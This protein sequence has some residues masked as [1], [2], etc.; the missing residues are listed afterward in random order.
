MQPRLTGRPAV[1]LQKARGRQDR[2]GGRGFQRHL[3]VA[4]AVHAAFVDVAGQHLDLADL[5]RPGAGGGGGVEIA[6][7]GQLDRGDDLWLE[8]PGA[9]AIVREGE[10]RVA[11]VE[12]ALDLTEVR[13]ERPERQ[14][15][16]ARNAVVRLG[17]GKGRV[18]FPGVNGGVLDAVLAD[19]ALAEFEE[20]F[21]E[22]GLAAV[23]LQD[24]FVHARAVEEGVDRGPRG[25][26]G[27]GLGADRG[28]ESVEISAA[29]GRL[30]LGGQ[31]ERRAEHRGQKSGNR[32]EPHESL[33]HKTSAD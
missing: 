26:G 18:V 4:V 22:K 29:G 33:H 3:A 32:A 5:A 17:A 31:A 16:A 25:P 1:E 23:V 14:D 9:A 8:N 12:I 13:L 10:K 28:D 20:A 6:V 11:G 19:Q 15:D 7:L 30:G 24:G 27:G 21:A 2:V